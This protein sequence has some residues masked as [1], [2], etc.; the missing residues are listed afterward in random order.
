MT[1]RTSADGEARR[2][3]KTTS[4]RRR[5]HG[6]G[7]AAGST[8]TVAGC[9]GKPTGGGTSAAT[10]ASAGTRPTRPKRIRTT[11]KYHELQLMKTY[12]ELNHNPDNNDL[13]QL[14]LKTGLSKRVLQAIDFLPS[15][16][17]LT[18]SHF[19]KTCIIISHLI[20]CFKRAENRADVSAYL[21]L[22]YFQ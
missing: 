12:F 8:L 21:S 7:Q 13:K 20:T 19:I 3:S 17:A 10:S 2:G 18:T 5:E 14:S 4:T 1:S 6:P 16:T 15:L 11:F 9:G 22:N